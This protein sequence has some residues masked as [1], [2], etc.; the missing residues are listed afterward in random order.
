MPKVFDRYGV[1]KGGGG[2]A[3]HGALTGLSDDD[4][5]HYIL[6]DA[7]RAF[8]AAPSSSVAASLPA[9][10][11]RKEEMDSA[12]GSIT[13]TFL[14]LLGSYSPVGHTHTT[15]DITSGVFPPVRLGTGSTG[16]TTKFLREDGSYATP[17]GTGGGGGS[18]NTYFPSGW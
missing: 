7:T 6:V 4:H 10:L 2:V 14:F 15:A 8:S 13:S 11:V 5:T 16:G 1:I 3:D 12:F 18:G 9:H 17:P